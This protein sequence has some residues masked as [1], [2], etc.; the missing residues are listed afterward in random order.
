MW[1]TRSRTPGWIVVVA[2]G[3]AFNSVVA[4]RAA[5]AG[6]DLLAAKDC[7]L[8]QGERIAFLGDS[9]T[10]GGAGP[11]GY[12]RLIDEA[13]AKA[14]PE[15]GVQV[16]YAGISGN[17]VPDLQKRLDADVLSKKPTLVFV[18]IGIND[19]WHSLHGRG[20]PKDQYEAGLRDLLAKMHGAGAK[21]ILATPSVIG[22][23]H[24][25]ANPFDAMLDEYAAISRKVAAEAGVT[26]CDLR[27][28]FVE[29]LRQNNPD[30]KDRGILTTDGVHLNAAGNRFVADRAAE[31]I[32]AALAKQP[33]PAAKAPKSRPVTGKK[34]VLIAGGPSHGYASHEHYAGCMLLARCLRENVPGAEAIVVKDG[35]PQDRSVLADAAAIVIF[36]DGGERHPMIP[37]L[38]ELGALMDQGVGLAC[39]HY[40]VEVPKGP[41]GDA[42]L[43]WLGGYFEVFW[44]VN[45]HWTAEFKS[46][47]DHPVARGLKP[48]AMDDEWYYHMRFVPDMKG[49]TPILSAV[50]PESTRQGKDGPRSGNP[51]VRA[52]KG[53]AE[54]LA[55]AFE[56]PGGGRGFGFTGG[57]WHWSWACDSFRTCVLNGIVWVAGMEVPPGGVPSKT[58]T[59]EELL[60]HQ[61]KPQPP[62]FDK[63]RVLDLMKQWK[64]Q[65][66][67]APKPNIIFVLADDLGYGDLGCYGQKVI[68]T[69]HLDR[70]AAEGMRFTD[71]YA[72]STVCAPSR[73][74]LM[75]GQH[76]GH[77]LVRGNA[78]VPLR[79]D[80][81]TVAKV[82]KQSGYA[83]GLVGKWGLGEADSTGIP[84]RQGFDTFF[85]Y[86]NQ[87]HAHNYYPEFLW[88]NETQVPLANVV[89]RPPGQ[90]DSPSGIATKRMAYSCDLM[91][92]EAAAFLR[93]HQDRPF[94]LYLAYTLP[95]ANN[96][97]GKQG[98]EV[99]DYGPY[100]DKDWPEPQKGHA[101]MI[102][103]LDGYVGR[104]LA[105]LKE[106]GLDEKTVVFFSSDN[107]P[108]KEGGAD[109]EFFRSSGP[110]Q[111]YK[112]SLH[113]GGIRVPMI[114]RWPGVIRP[115]STSE[116]VW[117]FEDFLPTAAELAGAKAPPGIDGISVVPTLRG[118]GPQPQ[119]DF[120]YWEFHE[121][122]SQQAVRMGPWKAVR[123]WQ[124]PIRL[125]DLRADLAE[126][127]DVAAEHPEIVAR[128]E[129]YLKTARTDSDDWPMREPR[130]PKPKRA[131]K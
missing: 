61:D 115:G 51:A 65:A 15:R 98:M 119:H 97:A 100:A 47:P 1:S 130:R 45:P 75:T 33:E 127:R 34:I 48:F 68:R 79:P 58:P 55:W 80:E 36:A 63:Q 124:Q 10:Q 50:P 54:H 76:T 28:R 35:W 2:L 6:L 77:C 21:V 103:R 62:G 112:R 90:P 8:A 107:G 59:F 49:V 14:H 64:D 94:F 5:G 74:V 129:A 11:G 46:F 106:L 57:H 24:D 29:H 82:L 32:A 111:G 99:P 86:L 95:H 13:I 18:Y 31:S 88:R 26:L 83:T 122:G 117:A 20:T 121:G 40:A 92:D 60:E 44:S 42:M 104:L 120:L 4:A 25:G 52:R 128:I 89:Q 78:R 102:T 39:L 12:C 84:N 131:A 30:N 105:D 66:A 70:M 53:M 16:I 110:L 23:K 113:D 43:K 7:P 123:P 108:H 96:E 22:E 41:P 17:R 27:K 109:P 71:C 3:M 114:V 38:D 116:L 37:H 93:K 125:F 126:Q 67:R 19:V 87:A 101:A 81:I 72:G 118:Q 73:C 56:R 85:G 9:I 91:A 69:P